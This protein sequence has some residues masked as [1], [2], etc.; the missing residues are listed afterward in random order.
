LEKYL[1]RTSIGT[2]SLLGSWQVVFSHGSILGDQFD[3]GPAGALS[4]YM[5]RLAIPALSI[6]AAYNTGA[7]RFRG[8]FSLG[9]SF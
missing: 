8:S 9:V 3:Q 6:G 4:F 2:L 5:S 7:G 1:L